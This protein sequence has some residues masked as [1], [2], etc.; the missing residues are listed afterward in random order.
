MT[1]ILMLALGAPP[2]DGQVVCTRLFNKATACLHARARAGAAPEKQ[3]LD[4]SLTS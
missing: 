1:I 2:R 4:A 3:H